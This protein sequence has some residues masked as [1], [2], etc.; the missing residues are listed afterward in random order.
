MNKYKYATTAQ[1]QSN[2]QRVHDM[3]LARFV[4]ELLLSGALLATALI[5][6]INLI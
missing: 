5:I 3:L 1:I 4:F 2:L 6:I